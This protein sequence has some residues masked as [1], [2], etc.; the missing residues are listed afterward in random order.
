MDSLIHQFEN[1]SIDMKEYYIKDFK[2][3]YKD[4]GYSDKRALCLATA[5]AKEQVEI[6]MKAAKSRRRNEMRKRLKNW[7]DLRVKKD[8]S[9]EI[10]NLFEQLSI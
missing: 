5:A 2:S 10:N 3:F 6:D 4:M 7:M 1:V 9:D 8:A